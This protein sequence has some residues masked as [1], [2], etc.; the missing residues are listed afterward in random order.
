[1]DAAPDNNIL[2]DGN[3]QEE[4]EKD[5]VNKYFEKLKK[6]DQDKEVVMSD[7]PFE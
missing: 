4:K 6:F 2:V 3:L 5:E 7:D 1:M